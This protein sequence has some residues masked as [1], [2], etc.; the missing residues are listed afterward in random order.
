MFRSQNWQSLDKSHIV[1][2]WMGGA[3]DGSFVCNLPCDQ[4]DISATLLSALRVGHDGFVFSED[5]FGKCRPTAFA[6]SGHGFDFI[7]GNDG[8]WYAGD[9][10]KF[11]PNDAMEGLKH[12][13]QAYCQKVAE[14][15]A[16]LK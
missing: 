2:Q 14:Y 8:V 13:S 11:Y 4:S 7:E 6:P 16:G 9:A 10:D 12:K 3:V 15:Y 5:I 1:M